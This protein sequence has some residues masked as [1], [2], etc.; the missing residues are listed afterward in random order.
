VASHVQPGERVEATVDALSDRPLQ[1][2][3]QSRDET[4]LHANATE[5]G[6]ESTERNAGD[7]RYRSD[8]QQSCRLHPMVRR[9]GLPNDTIADSA[10]IKNQ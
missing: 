7:N 2:R 6:L 8:A 3:K 10:R 9:I 1:R 5:H 4:N